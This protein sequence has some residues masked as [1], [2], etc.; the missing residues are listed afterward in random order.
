MMMWNDKGKRISFVHN[1]RI[2]GTRMNQAS[3]YSGF[4][5]AMIRIA[6]LEGGMGPG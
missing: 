4:S 5:S 3:I 2:W 1:N 6:P